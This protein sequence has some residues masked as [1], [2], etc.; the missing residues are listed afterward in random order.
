MALS[1]GGVVVFAESLRLVCRNWRRDRSGFTKG[2]TL[3]VGDML[4]RARL[5]F[6][7]V[8]HETPTVLWPMI[9]KIMWLSCR[10]HMNCTTSA[11]ECGFLATFRD[12]PRKSRLAKPTILTE[13]CYLGSIDEI[14]IRAERG[15]PTAMKSTDVAIESLHPYGDP[16]HDYSGG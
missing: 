7:R 10:I 2:R 12:L 4:Q 11:E 6:M 8:H 3:E 16:N 5:L 13:L 14:R 9:P 15:V 1:G